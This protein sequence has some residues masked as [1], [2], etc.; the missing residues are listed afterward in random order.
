[1]RKACVG[2][3]AGTN[4]VLSKS[5]T[6]T[7]ALAPA[8]EEGPQVL[9]VNQRGE[10]ENMTFDLNPSGLTLHGT[11]QKAEGQ[12]EALLLLDQIKRE[13]GVWWMPWQ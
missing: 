9:H 8:R 6:L 2:R 1:M 12:E 4:V 13:K 5:S 7:K 10:R 3:K 11:I